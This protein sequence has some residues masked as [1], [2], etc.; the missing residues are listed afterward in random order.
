M[1][2]IL[3][4]KAFDYKQH[5]RLSQGNQLYTR[6]NLSQCWVPIYSFGPSEFFVKEIMNCW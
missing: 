1:D 6:V 3:D 5:A 2:S 4:Y